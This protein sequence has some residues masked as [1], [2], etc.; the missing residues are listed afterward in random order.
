MVIETTD[1]GQIKSRRLFRN[2]LEVCFEVTANDP[3][4]GSVL[5]DWA[6][7]E[8]QNEPQS[9]W[10]GNLYTK[11]IAAAEAVNDPYAEILEKEYRKWRKAC[12]I[13]I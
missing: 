2:I 7:A 1:Y 13:W 9:S 3:V 6:K 4:M 11:A 8:L 5:W 12:G 10:Y